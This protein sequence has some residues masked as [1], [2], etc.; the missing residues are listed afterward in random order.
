MELGLDILSFEGAQEDEQNCNLHAR[1][2]FASSP[3]LVMGIAE[4]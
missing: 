2:C 3:T 1:Y 4:E